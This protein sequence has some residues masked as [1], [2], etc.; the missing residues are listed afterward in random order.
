MTY[1][2]VNWIHS[3]SMYPVVLYSELDDHRWETR[4]IEVFCD[5]RKGYASVE[6]VSGTTRLGETP[7]PSLSE[8]ASA[9]EFEPSVISR[10]NFETVW[11]QRRQH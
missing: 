6:E 1:L 9:P 4:K 2:K 3:N 8:I 10:D 11:A 5:G 7:I